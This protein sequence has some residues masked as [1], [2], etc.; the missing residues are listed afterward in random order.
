MKGFK[1]L[2]PIADAQRAILNA[3]THKSPVQ[4]MPT[5][6]SVG[7]YVAEDVVAPVDVPLFDRAAFDGYAV[8]SVDTLG[9]SRTNPITLRKMGKI[10]AGGEHHGVLGPGEA[11]EIA[12]GAP[13]PK[14]ADAVMPYEEAAD[15]GAYIEIYKPVPQY[16]YVSRKGEDV[17]AGEIVLR[18]GR[19]IRPW[20]IGVLA[21]LGIR[22]ISVYRLRAALIST[23]SELVELEEAPPPPGR[24]INSTRHVITALLRKIGVEVSY[25]GIVPDDVEKIHSAVSRAL[26]DHD[27]V[28][29]TGGASVGEPDYVVEAVA[30]L[31]PEVLIHGIAAR[32]GR[33]NSAAV[34]GG[35]P[36]VMLSGFPVASIVGFEVFIKPIIL[37]MVGAREEPAPV[38]KATLTRRVTTPINVRSFVRV[39]VVRRD[40]KLYAEPLAVTGSGILSTLT[41]GNGLLIIP[42]NREGYDEGDE[43]E[44]VLLGPVEG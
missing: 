39:R 14:G 23:G 12:T 41:R 31:K 7:L 32:P 16:Y 18:R 2:T 42:E 29:T 24:I 43:V 25:M 19:R 27:M 40:G 20:D 10:V 8:R 35:K 30:R 13:L 37:H 11:V 4:R 5:P 33:P 3:L 36:V 17:A 6:Q 21:S 38:A 1:A 26:A 9:A 28:I 15:R 22:E 44:V 34:V